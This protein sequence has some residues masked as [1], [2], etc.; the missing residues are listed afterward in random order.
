M[1]MTQLIGKAKCGT[2]C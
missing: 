2:L 1:P